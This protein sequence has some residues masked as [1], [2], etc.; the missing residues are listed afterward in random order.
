MDAVAAEAKAARHH[1]EWANVYN[2]VFIRWT[3]HVPAGLSGKD[4]ALAGRCDEL[5][6]ALEGEAAEA[7]E[8]RGVADA[9]VAG[10]GECCGPGAGRREAAKAEVEREEGEGAAG[11]LAGV[12]GQP[13]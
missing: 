5:A 6:V 7:A 9:V 3:T 8:L 12:G 11:S 10:A 4:V 13:S 2:R 1:P